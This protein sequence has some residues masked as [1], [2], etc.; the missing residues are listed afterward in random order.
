M[1]VMMGKPT[2]RTI[3]ELTERELQGL[4]HR[5]KAQALGMSLKEYAR[6]V[7]LDVQRLYQ[8]RPL[9]RRGALF[10]RARLP[11][12]HSTHSF[13]SSPL[14]E[15][16]KRNHVTQAQLALR[17]EV[18]PSVISQLES[19]RMVPSLALVHR[20]SRVTGMSLE[21]LT[22]FFLFGGATE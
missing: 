4:E 6:K 10:S 13:Y 14:K 7:G 22:L 5:R 1:P 9:V 15:W 20:L 12:E 21:R 8:L 18:H 17:C 16:R 11:Q 2:M 3:E 19:R